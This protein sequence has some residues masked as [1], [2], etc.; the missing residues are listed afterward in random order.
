M[1]VKN[2]SFSTVSKNYYSSGQVQLINFTKIGI[3]G[4]GGLGS[5]C[6]II[7]ARCGFENFNIA[8][9]DTVSVSNL[10]RQAYIPDHLGKLKVECLSGIL[11][12]INPDIK[13]KAFPCRITSDNIHHVFDKCDVVVE[14]FDIAESKSML[15]EEFW[16]SGKLLV[17]ASG[18]CGYGK[19]DEIRIRKIKNNIYV[20]GDGYSEAGDKFK[21][22][23][24]SVMIAA[25]KQ[26]D[27]V[28]DW[29]L[30]D[31]SI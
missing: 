9:F 10:N 14:A 23:A 13:V 7:L 3:A 31:S 19:S 4:A 6:A 17:S 18:I 30:R 21:P 16:D 12:K 8:D 26:A 1:H 24:P 11:Q 28:L 5:N 29:V 22:Y 20:V 27:I 2:F 15:I 25:A